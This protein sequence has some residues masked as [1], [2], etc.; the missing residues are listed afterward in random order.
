MRI[1]IY[2]PLSFGGTYQYLK[3][4]VHDLKRSDK[5]SAVTVIMP[6]NAIYEG[7][8]CV[9]LLKSDLIKSDKK[10]VK[11]I[12]FLY[13]TFINPVKFYN[14]LRHQPPSAIVF[15]D[16]DQWS[17]WFA[18][19]FFK[20]LRK[21]HLFGIILHDP[22]RDNYTPFKWLST[23]TMKAQMSFMDIAFYHYV[24][25][26]KSYY[27]KDI[28][29]VNIPHGIFHKATASIDELFYHHILAQ[30]QG[31]KIISIV[32][33]IRDEKNYELVIRALKE[34]KG[35]KL[36]IVG[37]SANSG[38]LIEEYK[39]IIRELELVDRVI[40]D[41]RYISDEEFS[42]AI[43]A[44]DILCLYYKKSFTSQSGVLNSIA[45]FQKPVVIADGESA[46]SGLA[47]TF[48]IGEVVEPENINA[49]VAA[50]KRMQSEEK[51]YT[52]SWKKYMEYASWENSSK[53]IVESFL[54]EY[55]RWL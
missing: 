14:W 35:I 9:K 1:V 43:K 4:L 12:H 2:N 26:E 34:L 27:K 17:G 50:I 7:E 32:G 37:K 38:V 24:L 42:A 41:E 47:K 31:M 49:F 19:Y 30:K 11:K 28:P 18:R 22:D 44:S 36:L 20:R 46:M 23:F 5:V 6:E 8:A 16:F 13:R 51:D 53:I 15:N 21:K 3:E 10:W 25:P 39:R 55:G 48:M 52:S 33:N 40:W 54:Q 45:P 29:Y